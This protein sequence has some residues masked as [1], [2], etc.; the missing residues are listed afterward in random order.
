[1]E[2]EN[3]DNIL[4]FKKKS[5]NSEF[6]LSLFEKILDAINSKIDGETP[7]VE[8]MEL[9]SVIVCILAHQSK[10]SPASLLRCFSATVESIYED[11]DDK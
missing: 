8:V 5:E 3:K 7:T 10:M 9:L 1:M 4:K 11:E 6:N 2:I